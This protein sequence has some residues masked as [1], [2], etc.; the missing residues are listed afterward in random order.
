MLMWDGVRR[1]M[2]CEG[3]STHL[4]FAAQQVACSVFNKNPTLFT[5]DQVSRCISQGAPG[6]AGICGGEDDVSGDVP[7]FRGLK[8]VCVAP[9]CCFL[10]PCWGTSVEW[11]PNLRAVDKVELIMPISDLSQD[12][13]KLLN[14]FKIQI[15]THTGGIWD[16]CSVGCSPDSSF[17]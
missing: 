5:V 6:T 2:A 3:Q 4:G 10:R 17:G 13:L 14:C 7:C 15:D 12:L 16:C 1:T 11:I 9:S 8:S